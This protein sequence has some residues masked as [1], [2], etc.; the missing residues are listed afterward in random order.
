MTRRTLMLAAFLLL[1]PAPLTMAEG[2]D[3]SELVNGKWRL[4]GKQTNHLGTSEEHTYDYSY[5]RTWALRDGTLYVNRTEYQETK[6]R[7][8]VVEAAYRSDDQWKEIRIR[9][10]GRDTVEYTEKGEND[11]FGSYSV[12]AKASRKTE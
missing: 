4:E 9:F 2:L 6:V 8:D 11:A 1:I 7:G 5:E 3:A 10:V 12:S